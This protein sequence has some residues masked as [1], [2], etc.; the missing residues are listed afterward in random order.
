MAGVMTHKTDVQK[1]WQE[2]RIVKMYCRSNAKEKSNKN[3]QSPP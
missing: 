2:N 3:G 1:H